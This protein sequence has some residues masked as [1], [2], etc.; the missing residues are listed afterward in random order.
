MESLIAG[1][2]RKTDG[3]TVQGAEAL[4]GKVSR[5]QEDIRKVSRRKEKI[6]GV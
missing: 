4:E 3:S 6:L 1:T 5:R 2:L